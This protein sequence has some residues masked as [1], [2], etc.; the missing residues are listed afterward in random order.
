MDQT[1]R[2]KCPTKRATPS[3]AARG[4]RESLAGIATGKKNGDEDGAAQPLVRARRGLAFARRGQRRGR[5]QIPGGPRR[6]T[7]RDE[8]GRPPPHPPEAGT[9]FPPGVRANRRR[10]VREDGRR[11]WGTSRVSS[12]TRH[13]SEREKKGTHPLDALRRL[14]PLTRRPP[15]KK[16]RAATSGQDD[17]AIHCGVSAA[18]PSRT[19]LVLPSG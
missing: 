18:L 4:Q 6:A 7:E 13:R 14:R 9:I 15:V 3:K 19:K 5:R 10:P 16:D 17:A 11:A 8:A 2:P 1:S 12:R